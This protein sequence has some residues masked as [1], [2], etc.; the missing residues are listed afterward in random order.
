MARA[1]LA[2]T[3]VL[4]VHGS[5]YPYNFTSA[6]PGSLRRLLE[7]PPLG[8]SLGDLLGNIALFLPYGLLALLATPAHWSTA[9]RLGLTMASAIVLA[10]LLQTAQAWLPSR[11]TSLRDIGWN[12]SGA[13]TGA[14]LAM[15]AGRASR[16]R[17]VAP[18]L[19]VPGTRTALAL[20]GAYLAAE[21]LPLVPTLDVSQL[22][23]TLKNLF[24]T[25]RWH[26]LDALWPG[27]RMFAAGL[28]LAALVPANRVLPGLGMLAVTVVLGHTVVLGRSAD[29]SLVCG[30][31]GGCMA[32]T[33]IEPWSQARRRL[34]VALVL[35]TAY[36]ATALAPFAFGPAARAF[37]IVPFADLLEGSL[38]IN[39]QVFLPRLFVFATLLWLAAPAIRAAAVLLAAW[40]FLLELAQTGLAGR[41][42]SITDAVSVI[43]L[44]MLLA[45]MQGSRTAA[46]A[47]TAASP[48]RPRD[49]TGP[50]R[51]SPLHAA[52]AVVLVTVAVGLA[53]WA[54]VRVP[55]VP[56][57]VRELLRADASFLASAAAALA[58]LWFGA[59]GAFLGERLA[60]ARRAWLVLPL[61]TL[62][63]ATLSLL[64]L[65][66][67]IT[68]ESIGDVAG[69]NNLYWFVTRRDLWGAGWRDFFLA[70]PGPGWVAFFE[71]PVRYTALVAPL[72]VMLAVAHVALAAPVVRWGR[73]TRL[74]AWALPG[75]WLCKAIAF[76][77]SSTDN[78]NELIARD[79]R[80]GLGGGG[81]LYALLALAAVSAAILAR[82]RGWRLA[83]AAATLSLTL[84]LS[85]WLAL[86]GLEAR[87]TK[88]QLE[89]S[90]VQFLLGPDRATQ[91]T[92]A[93]LALRWMFGHVTVVAVLALGMRLAQLAVNSYRAM[94]AN[95]D[96][97]AGG[98]IA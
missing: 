18:W 66:L 21:L 40:V 58:L 80:W 57:N 96:Q 26:V 33:L 51:V 89:F 13:A 19:G 74:L 75:L 97:G 39:L 59:G 35:L 95:D 25:P 41:T 24:I 68:G 77:W 9:V 60:S 76:D 8:M 43:V 71:R 12:I 42:P 30:L 62:A 85:W 92:A 45:R 46:A 64:L 29:L 91:L 7:M 10:A 49:T 84:P 93:V 3:V 2:V 55:G 65:S 94:A 98:T 52:G 11:V 86:H 32:W 70:L 53:L 1:T 23:D 38:L 78:L 90:A 6:H 82:A 14:S 83:V 88:Y 5:L 27:A 56:Y 63:A 34:A 37:N 72:F 17:A 61:G 48:A 87:V 79:G 16:H 54:L 20:L 73:A 44:G 31:L 81:Y 69:S 50:P 15:L 47:A 4:I 28:L 67:G 36:S 22:H